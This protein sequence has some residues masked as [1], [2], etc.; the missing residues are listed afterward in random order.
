MA[1]ATASLFSFPTSGNALTNLKVKS[2]DNDPALPPPRK[3]ARRDSGS[4][5]RKPRSSTTGSGSRQIELILESAPQA[6]SQTSLMTLVEK[7]IRSSLLPDGGI[8]IE[9]SF[10]GVFDACK[11]LVLQSNQGHALERIL[12]V[13][14]KNCSVAIMK[15]LKSSDIPLPAW[16]TKLNDRWSWWLRRI[17]VLRSALVYL[18]VAYL[19]TNEDKLT[20]QDAAFHRFEDTVVASTTVT[21]KLEAALKRW[22]EQRRAGENTEDYDDQLRLVVDCMSTLGCYDDQVH[23]PYL[24]FTSDHYTK[25]SQMAPETNAKDYLLMCIQDIS[26][27]ERRGADILREET[28]RDASVTALSGLAMEHM[29]YLAK[30]GLAEIITSRNKTLFHQ[31]YNLIG[32]LTSVSTTWKTSPSDALLAHYRND[33]FERVK[34]TI[35]DTANESSMVENLLELKEFLDECLSADYIDDAQQND[36]KF[37]HATSEAFER[38]F[39]TRKIKPAELIA[40]HVDSLMRRGQKAASDQEFFAQ[41]KRVLTLYRYSHDKDVFRAFY[42]RALAKRLLLGR[43]ASDDFEKQVLAELSKSYDAAFSDMTQ[44]FNDLAISKDLM[45]TYRNTKD[46]EPARP[47]PSLTV[48]VLQHSVWPVIRKV[49]KLDAP[50]ELRLPSQMEHALNDF[51][52]FYKTQHSNRKLT[53]AHYL[54]TA[55]LVARFPSG[56]KELSVSLYQAAVLLLFSERDDWSTEEIHGRLGLALPDLT[57]T[58]Q[59]LA[60]G[61]KLVLRRT[62]PRQGKDVRMDDRFSFN[63]DFTDTKVKLHINTIQQND[64]MEETQQ[65]VKV[66]DQYREASLDA[67]I[68][69]IMKAA[70]T[71]KH[72]QLVNETIDAVSKHFRPEVKAIKERIDSLIEREFLQRNED[73]GGSNK[74][75]DTYSYLA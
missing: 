17:R 74:L 4:S 50:V 56:K 20:I 1:A 73:T 60:L 16:M 3:A 15:E 59:S 55:T 9:T 5:P 41:L 62:Q 39:S 22:S 11:V 49:S 66:I 57:P 51:I 2:Y 36:R 72:Q 71:M 68:V 54:G 31:L 10:Q 63:E 29:D 65:A 48:M 61:R 45:E 75:R 37:T 30:D 24:R 25:K 28:R 46:Q 8:P 53:W 43:S 26:D 27:E 44:M 7:F 38:G 40:K 19:A 12:D 6:S 21:L 42:T 52:A 70:K 32:R 13:S 14:L 18:D 23:Q 58:L 34:G 33:V 47:D 35:L 64:T 69:R 67:A